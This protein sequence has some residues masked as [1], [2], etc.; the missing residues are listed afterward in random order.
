MCQIGVSRRAFTL[1]ELLVVIAIIAIL[2]GLLLPAVQKV[3]ETAARMQSMNNLKQLALAVHQFADD[4][5]GLLPDKWGTED[6]NGKLRSVHVNIL[7]YIEQGVVYRAYVAS[8]TGSLTDSYLIKMFYSPSDPTLRQS[9]FTGYTSYPVNGFLF[10]GQVRLSTVTDGTTN[11]LMFAEHYAASCGGIAFRWISASNQAHAYSPPLFFGGLELRVDRRATF[12]D[13]P[14]G[15]FTPT[16]VPS[17]TFQLRPS[18]AD[19]D[20]R[21]AQGPYRSG[22]LATLAD[23][24]V[25]IL[26]KGMS[27]ETYWGAVTPNGGEVLGND[28]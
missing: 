2:I 6:A 3:R 27:P 22:M 4:R 21:M 7:P 14:L 25:R 24:S 8:Q 26:S 10:T 23:G 5:D 1:L 28:W 11:T 19:C 13:E 9:E 16:G 12:A 20:S 17:Q 18:I 15:D